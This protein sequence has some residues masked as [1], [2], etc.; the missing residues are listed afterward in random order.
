MTVDSLKYVYQ[1]LIQPHFDY[2]AMVWGNC[3]RTLKERLQE[4]QNRAARVITGD[5]YDLLSETILS[6]LEMETSRRKK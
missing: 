5:D 1:T 2:C 6:K 4:L 3:T